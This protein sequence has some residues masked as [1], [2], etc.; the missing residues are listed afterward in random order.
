M[1]NHCQGARD[2]NNYKEAKR[3]AKNAYKQGSHYAAE[4]AVAAKF[5]M[6]DAKLRYQGF[7]PVFASDN[8]PTQIITLFEEILPLTRISLNEYEKRLKRL[9]SGSRSEEISER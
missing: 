8:S 6:N 7:K 1:G 2:E 5:K 4:G 9:I 3:H